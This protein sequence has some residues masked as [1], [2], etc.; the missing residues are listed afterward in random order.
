MTPTPVSC[1]AKSRR[2]CPAPNRL[3]EWLQAVDSCFGVVNTVAEDLEV[4]L[5]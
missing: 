3:V 1:F 5:H 4:G 2:E